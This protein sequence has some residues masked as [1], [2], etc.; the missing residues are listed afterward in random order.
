MHGFGVAGERTWVTP[1]S[2]GVGRAVMRSPFVTCRDR[3]SA[4]I[5]DRD[6][7]RWYRSLNGRWWFRLVDRPELV[8]ERFASVDLDPSLGEW[9]PVVV[10]DRW[11]A[12]GP[13]SDQTTASGAHSGSN[14]TGLYRAAVSIPTEWIGRR[15]VLHV[16]GAAS[17]LYVY[18]NGIAVGMGKD[19]HLPSEFDVTQLVREGANTIALIVVGCSDGSLIEGMPKSLTGGITGDIYCFATELV[20][21]DD[22]HVVADV[23]THDSMT[24]RLAVEVVV[25]CPT[26]VGIGSGWRVEV[27]LESADDSLS[28]GGVEAVQ[29][30]F[31]PIVL[32]VPEFPASTDS[33]VD[34]RV[35]LKASAVVPGCRL[36]SAEDPNRYR[37]LVT[38]V[39]P[40]GEVVESISQLVGFRTVE[41]GEGELRI[42]GSSLLIR[43][44]A[45]DGTLDA[46]RAVQDVARLRAELVMMKR[47]NVNAVRFVGN[48][49]DSR[50][51]DLCDELGL[52]VFED[53]SIEITSSSDALVSDP[54]SVFAI[55]DRGSRM[56]RRDKNHPSV[57]GWFLASAPARDAEIASRCK[58]NLSALAG[59]IRS[60]DPTRV[61]AAEESPVGD[62]VCQSFAALDDVLDRLRNGADGDKPILQSRYCDSRGNANGGLADWLGAFSANHGLVGGF[63]WAWSDLIADVDSSVS[64]VALPGLAEHAHVGAPV[65][66]TASEHDLRRRRVRITNRYQ[67]R[68]LSA[69]VATWDLALDGV[70]VMQGEIDLPEIAAGET[71][72]VELPFERPE[73]VFA[74]SILILTLRFFTSRSEL[75]A[76]AGH[77]VA[78]Q[79]LA[80]P[81]P[82]KAIVP[83]PPLAPERGI[84]VE[85]DQVGG[86]ARVAVGKLVVEIDEATGD[87]IRLRWVGQ[88]LLLSPPRIDLWRAPTDIDRVPA[89][90]CSQSAA[91]RW[92]AWGLN[93][94]HRAPVSANLAV[95]SDGSVTI[96]SRQKIWGRDSG[97]VMTARHRLTVVCSGDLIF[98]H[99]LGVPGEVDDLPRVGVSFS[100]AGE[101]EKLQWVG[102]GPHESYP[103]RRSGAALGRWHTTVTDAFVPYSRPQENGSHV[104]TRWFALTRL[105]DTSGRYGTTGA[106]LLIG[107]IEPNPF[108][109]SA[110]HYSSSD[111]TTAT[112]RASLVARPEVIVHVDAA[113]RGLRGISTDHETESMH[114]HGAETWIWSWRMRAFDPLVE[115]PSDLG[116]QTV[117]F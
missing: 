32:E 27:E 54:R 11:Q 66:V 1:E 76:D 23:D 2:T 95:N 62:L 16:G 97:L 49:A 91:Q 64:P 88:D 75:W 67:F 40:A 33:A 73:T 20:H 36:W 9:S 74:D 61:I 12:D 105:G 58:E 46:S 51:L 4:R 48:P 117:V 31:E 103:D 72:V 69:L 111:L 96:A 22:V 56:V 93:H 35:V 70:P 101:L 85:R 104:D 115:D 17:V 89:L 10:P 3:E 113:H 81:M 18:V 84:E 28:V 38:L 13:L 34:C 98:E 90:G 68:D 99:E 71:R 82:A 41:V 94:L 100:V 55:I 78:W 86:R 25:G 102:R 37:V 44:V 19:S 60:F 47:A 107:A 39:D 92:E 63:L 52:Y 79:Q 65:V 14:P 110:S 15:I 108:V 77:E 80:V 83:R 24:G 59:W 7:S 116:V 87:V 21:V 6:A 106:G 42:N 43:G 109:F 53:A 30:E 26:D 114:G 5:A 50:L 45:F 57:I 112:S 8:P 29:P